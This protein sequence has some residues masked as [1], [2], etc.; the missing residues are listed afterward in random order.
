MNGPKRARV[1]EPAVSP[2][3]PD[4]TREAM[5]PP[6]EETAAGLPS[7]P[8][9]SGLIWPPPEAE[10]DAI[11]VLPLGPTDVLSPASSASRPIGDDV[12]DRASGRLTSSEFDRMT[13]PARGEALAPE[14]RRRMR[15]GIINVAAMLVLVLAAIAAGTYL[16]VKDG[17]SDAG[18]AIE[19]K[20][21]R[22][23]AQDDR[24]GASRSPGPSVSS[25]STTEI[26]RSAPASQ[27]SPSDPARGRETRN[28]SPALRVPTVRPRAAPPLAR[29]RASETL[30]RDVAENP[31]TGERAAAPSVAG[32][33]LVPGPIGGVAA[34]VA[35]LPTVSSA[36]RRAETSG[37]MARAADLAGIRQTVERFERAYEA[38]DADAARTV[39]PSLQ[40]E[41]LSRA[42][43]GLKS[44]A[45][46]FDRC[47]INLA[48]AAATVA[49]EA[50]T[51][52]VP[53]FGNSTPV[54][55]AGHWQFTLQRIEDNWLIASVDVTRR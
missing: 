3:L 24:L 54:V 13:R 46:T 9:S 18:R 27:G 23:A 20:D 6:A 47:A 37:V 21:R 33:A 31:A 25:P 30:T 41:R 50:V 48:G 52:V 39:W 17:Q 38:L 55:V 29:P 26:G 53:R 49:C 35:A 45:M 16:G 28:P 51:R 5:A 1:P 22:Q 44:Q 11:E 15:A 40:V 42:F 32:D 4:E 2:A 36:A 34:T 19:Q 43:S 14:P 7:P 8:V 10:L 12:S